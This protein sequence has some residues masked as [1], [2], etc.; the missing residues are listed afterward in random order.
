MLSRVIIG[1]PSFGSA[2]TAVI[3]G[4]RM[5]RS[6]IPHDTTAARE[7]DQ[8][9]AIRARSGLPTTRTV[10]VAS[11][12]PSLTSSSFSQPEI[13]P[14]NLSFEPEGNGASGYTIRQP[15]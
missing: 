2:F 7:S 5:G 15:F 9:Q 8:G 14:V 10:Q 11:T 12:S 13:Q 1:L 4:P 6:W 3:H